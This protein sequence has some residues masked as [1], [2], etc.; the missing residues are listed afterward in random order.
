MHIA[1]CMERIDDNSHGE[2]PVETETTTVLNQCSLIKDKEA[3]E[4]CKKRIGDSWNTQQSAMF[5]V[6]A[7]FSNKGLLISRTPPRPLMSRYLAIKNCIVLLAI[8]SSNFYK[9]SPPKTRH[10]G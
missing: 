8:S 2:D 7:A 5:K 4:L 3:W 9:R 6:K 1:Q 10:R